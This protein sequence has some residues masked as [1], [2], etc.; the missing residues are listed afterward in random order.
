MLCSRLPMARSTTTWSD[1]RGLRQASFTPFGLTPA[2]TPRTFGAQVRTV[3]RRVAVVG[4]GAGAGRSS[5]PKR[6]GM[7]RE[8]PCGSSRTPDAG[9]S[10]LARK[11]PEAAPATKTTAAS[12]AVRLQRRRFGRVASVGAGMDVG[13]GPGCS[14]GSGRSKRALSANASSTS[15][16]SGLIGPRSSDAAPDGRPIPGVERWTTSGPGV[17][18]TVLQAS[19]SRR[20]RRSFCSK[21]FALCDG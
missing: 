4:T 12:T 20:E 5:R 17:T 1:P 8:P 11:P 18:P 9:P 16:S 7:A 3:A 13:R 6:W 19:V 10:S 21:K 2:V 15:A 14:R